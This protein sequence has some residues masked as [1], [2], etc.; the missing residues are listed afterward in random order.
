[1]QKQIN[2]LAV[3][4]YGNK[5]NTPIIFVHG[6]PLDNT[7]WKNQIKFLQKDYYCITYDVR[8]LGNSYVGD[9]QYTMEAYVWDLFSIINEL[10]LNKPVLCGL[11]MGGYISLRAVETNQSKFGGLILCDTKSEADNDT[12]KLILA[13]K[14]N[15]IN[16]K[17]IEHFAE[18]FLSTV[19]FE[20]TIKNNSKLYNEFLEIAKSQNPIGVKGA[21]IAMLSRTDTTSFLEKIKLPTLVICGAFDNLTPPVQMRKLAEK[22]KNSEFSSIPFAGH[23]SPLENPSMVNDLIS[24]FM[25]RKIQS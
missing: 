21:L 3:Y 11:S 2:G 19:F 15:Q 9:G 22:I 17:G 25:K 14:I 23:M 4:T 10:N 18:E 20:D 6:F 5:K 13:F 12:G 16:T 8:G 7:M 24:G 1:M